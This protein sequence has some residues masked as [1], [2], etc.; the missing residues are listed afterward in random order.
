MKSN[1]RGFTVIGAAIDAGKRRCPTLLPVPVRV[2]SDLRFHWTISRRRSG[3]AFRESSLTQAALSF[4]A[5]PF[6]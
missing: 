4:P 3:P 2:G 1:R 6:R 5:R